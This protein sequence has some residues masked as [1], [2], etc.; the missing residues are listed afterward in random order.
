MIPGQQT[1]RFFGVMTN[2]DADAEELESLRAEHRVL[3]ER[4][5]GILADGIYDDVEIQRLKKR[6]LR[7][8]DQMIQ[9][10][11]ALLPDIIA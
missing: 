9:L 7:I 5:D 10:E 4:I 11:S 1:K 3:D 6:K 2:K 8:K